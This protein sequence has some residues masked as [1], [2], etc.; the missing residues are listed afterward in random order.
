MP[1]Q[2][3]VQPRRAETTKKK[4]TNNPPNRPHSR[5]PK[6]LCSGPAHR[7]LPFNPKCTID[8]TAPNADVKEYFKPCGEVVHC[9]DFR[10]KAMAV[11]AFETDE[12]AKAAMKMNGRTIELLDE[13]KKPKNPDEPWCLEVTK[14]PGGEGTPAKKAAEPKTPAKTPDKT[15]AKK[16]AQPKTPKNEKS[17]PKSC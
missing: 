5:F 10:G 14:Y 3:E 16:D 6:G 13:K 11:L 1:R 8:S 17:A 7:G 12:G 2:I 9:I 15:P 4:T